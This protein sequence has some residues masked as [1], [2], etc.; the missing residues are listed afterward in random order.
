MYKNGDKVV[1]FFQEKDLELNK[2]YTV[3]SYFIGAYDDDISLKETDGVYAVENFKSL[4]DVR[5][6][7]LR[8]I[9]KR[10]CLKK[11]KE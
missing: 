3:R 6:I 5:D 1:C 11:V 7:K 9:K 8:K 2:I 10:I 4:K